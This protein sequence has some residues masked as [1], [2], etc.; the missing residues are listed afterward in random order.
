MN[1]K[2]L[3]SFFDFLAIKILAILALLIIQKLVINVLYALQK[4]LYLNIIATEMILISK[5]CHRQYLS[6]EIC[7]RSVALLLTALRPFLWSLS[8]YCVWPSFIQTKYFFLCQQ[9]A[10]SDS[11]ENNKDRNWWIYVLKIY[12]VNM[13]RYLVN[14]FELFI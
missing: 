5:D 6:L 2:N 14:V 4:R 8:N 13:K 9:S 11:C 10:V 7:N 3:L 12:V 1:L